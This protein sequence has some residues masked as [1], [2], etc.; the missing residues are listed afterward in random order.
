MYC[1]YY[2]KKM[3]STTLCIT[4]KDLE[5]ARSIWEYL[6]AK[7]YYIVSRKP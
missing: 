3:F 5:D 2:Q 4:L 1:I 6:A 7:G